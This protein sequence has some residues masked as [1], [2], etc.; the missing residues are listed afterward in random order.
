M[1]STGP[2]AHLYILDLPLSRP[3]VT[4]SGVV[5]HREV[6]IVSVS[7]GDE[8]G[9]GEAAP[10][11]GQDET[12][13]SVVEAARD[14][15]TT[16]TLSAALD[17]AVCD[18]DARANGRRL[19][20]DVPADRTEL[21]ISAAVGM[22]AAVV[23]VVAALVADGITTIKAKVAP[24]RVDHIRDIRDAYPDL[25]MGVDANASFDS[26]SWQELMS[27]SEENVSY[28]EQPTADLSVPWL[29][30]LS[31]AGF[32]V[33]ADES[34]RNP[35]QAVEVLRLPGVSGVVVK[36]GRLGWRGSLAVIDA[37]RKMAKRWRASG[38]LETGVGRAYTELLAGAKDAFVSDVAPADMYFSYD[39]VR[40]RTDGAYI[41]AATADG[42]GIDV[43]KDRIASLAADEFVINPM[44]VPN[45]D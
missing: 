6:A 12:F 43:D 1:N 19:A 9:W 17:E 16:P 29:V 40:P 14:G 22:D 20:S 30:E 39:A 41:I 3:F 7:L 15:G 24:G 11:P 8:T 21:P 33:F 37:A 23:D 25:T 5:S 38:L 26:T 10:Y 4:A 27:L 35:T 13:G 36:P 32:I 28:L 18:L 34:V 44:A 42:V 31:D 2:I 45:L